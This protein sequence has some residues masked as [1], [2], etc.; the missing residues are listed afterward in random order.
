MTQENLLLLNLDRLPSYSNDGDA[1]YSLLLSVSLAKNVNAG[2]AIDQV[3]LEPW[4][5]DIT[6]VRIWS[7]DSNNDPVLVGDIDP[8][9][10]YRDASG[11]EFTLDKID[12]LGA[13]LEARLKEL[14]IAGQGDPSAR[15]VFDP[16]GAALPPDENS[17]RWPHLLEDAVR[18]PAP[19][20]QWLNLVQIIRMPPP[21]GD[22]IIAAPVFK[23]DADFEPGRPKPADPN[24]SKGIWVV[25][26]NN[27]DVFAGRTRPF[28]TNTS[29]L[30]MWAPKPEVSGKD[31]L[32]KLPLEIADASDV[33]T[34]L[35][36]ALM[37]LGAPAT[38]RLLTEDEVKAV[39]LAAL[40]AAR[41]GGHSGVGFKYGW[42]DHPTRAQEAHRL[43]RQQAISR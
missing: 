18:L 38:N 30:D 32:A 27:T 28:P 3:W 17:L 22:A 2:D 31:W 16:L 4:K 25:P 23:L 15:L 20:G 37:D 40:R 12:K 43:A 35:A 29:A 21:S 41:R 26:Y 13:A 34:H 6:K 14:I 36:K 10:K 1:W 7:I 42:W 8:E 9:E 24:D 19:L 5:F 39:G 11:V 33:L